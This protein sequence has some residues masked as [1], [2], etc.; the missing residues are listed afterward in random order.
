[1]ALELTSC[2]TEGCDQ[3]SYVDTTGL[4]SVENPTGYGIDNAVTG[5]ADFDSYELR[6][7]YPGSDF[8]GDPDFVYDLQALVPPIDAD[9][10]YTW[11]ITKQALGL[12]SLVSGTYN[13][14]AVGIK[15]SV[16]YVTDNLVIFIGDLEKKLDALMLDWNPKSPCKK[17]CLDRAALYAEFLVVKCGGAC[18]YK[19]ADEIIKNLYQKAK[20]CC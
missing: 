3:F 2:I 1:M 6:I 9:D 13:F 12:D 5:P 15:D 4:F 18:D 16:S 19:K 8:T 11:V 14:R 17:G 7:W 20:T 10:H